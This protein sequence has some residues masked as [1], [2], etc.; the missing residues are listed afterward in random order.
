MNEFQHLVNKEEYQIFLFSCPAIFPFSFALHT[1][2][3]VNRK[4]II[5]RWEVFQ[6]PGQNKT[7]WG[8]IHKDFYP[9]FVGIAKFSFT[10]KYLWRQ[11]SLI[12]Y[13]EG[14]DQSFA[15]KMA[16]F[17]ENSPKSYPYRDTYYL[18]GPNSN[19]YIEW[20]LNHFPE[21]KLSLPKRAF[22]KNKAPK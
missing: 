1:W 7:S 20:L 16:E 11:P 5:S 19:S 9:P 8:H 18:K 2:I 3:V 6:K 17:I 14:D 12:G 22:G 13:V 15:C 4:G 21:S 10:E